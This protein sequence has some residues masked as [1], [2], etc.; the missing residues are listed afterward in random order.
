MNAPRTNLERTFTG[1]LKNDHLKDRFLAVL[2]LNQ[3]LFYEFV[4]R[5]FCSVQELRLLIK[6]VSCRNF[7]LPS[8]CR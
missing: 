3:T 2:F 5:D 8:V 6:V 7:V 4:L 1:L